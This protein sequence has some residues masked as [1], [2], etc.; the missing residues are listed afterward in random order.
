MGSKDLGV[1]AAERV[2]MHV[3]QRS[4]TDTKNA[5]SVNEKEISWTPRLYLI[6]FLAL[7]QDLASC[8]V[9]VLS[10]ELTPKPVAPFTPPGAHTALMSHRWPA[11][12]ACLD[13]G[14]I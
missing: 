3:R 11:V 6:R 10:I 13:G 5:F 1:A 8:A 9:A 2:L 4:K 7:V 12:R 14:R